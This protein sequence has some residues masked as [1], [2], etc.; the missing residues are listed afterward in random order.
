MAGDPAL[1]EAV[2]GVFFPELAKA[3]PVYEDDLLPSGSAPYMAFEWIGSQDYLGEQKRKGGRRTRGANFTSADFAFRFIRKDGRVQ[4]VLGEWKYTEYYVS[5]DLG[6]PVRKANY[7]R[8]FDRADGVFGPQRLDLYDSLFFDPFYQLMRLQLL[9]QEMET[10]GLGREMDA[11][12]VSVLHICPTANRE[13]REH[14][15]SPRLKAMFPGKGTLDIWKDLLPEDR[16]LSIS[17][18]DLLEAIVQKGW[19]IDRDWVRYL[20]DRFRW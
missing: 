4:L 7:L 14:V 11:D 3:V 5:T 17:V 16:F 12:V 19:S 1:V 9:A 20:G 2:L 15:T 10:G 18:E 13:F 6:I 8:T